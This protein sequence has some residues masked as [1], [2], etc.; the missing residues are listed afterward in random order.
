MRGSVSP[1]S[2]QDRDMDAKVTKIIVQH[3]A[4]RV[5][6]LK[7]QWPMKRLRSTA[8]VVYRQGI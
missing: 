4:E 7:K 8:E 2:Q 3:R 1:G 5:P 6:L